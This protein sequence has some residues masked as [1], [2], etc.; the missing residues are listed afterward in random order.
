MEVL[1]TN[2]DNVHAGAPVD[3]L[4]IASQDESPAAKGAQLGD[5]DF[6]G[7]MEAPC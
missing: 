7:P 2:P 6:D 4:D 3:V 1:C 5:T